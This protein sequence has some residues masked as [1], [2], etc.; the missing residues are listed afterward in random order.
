MVAGR[1]GSSRLSSCSRY[2][3][4]CCHYLIHALGLLPER[5]SLLALERIWIA[6]RQC[7]EHRDRWVFSLGGN[8]PAVVPH[9]QK[10][11]CFLVENWNKNYLVTKSTFN[12]GSNF[13][14]NLCLGGRQ[15]TRKSGTV[16]ISQKQQ[17][18]QV[19]YTHARH[20][21]QDCKQWVFT[22]TDNLG[23][24]SDLTSVISLQ[25]YWWTYWNATFSSLTATHLQAF[26]PRLLHARPA[27][28]SIAGTISQ[29][30]HGLAQLLRKGCKTLLLMPATTL[31]PCVEAHL[32]ARVNTWCPSHKG[33]KGLV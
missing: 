21:N 12:Q 9:F 31:L 18:P 24:N 23:T 32:W 10:Y 25:N 11:L 33:R 20:L 27:A 2:L 22:K 17:V 5:K 4:T 30:P 7:C 16:L 19:A 3:G 1:V 13:E 14:N 15:L 6:G 28:V 29:Q 8:S 26:P